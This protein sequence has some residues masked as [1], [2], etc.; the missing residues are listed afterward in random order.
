MDENEDAFSNFFYLESSRNPTNF[1]IWSINHL[2]CLAWRV[3]RD[4]IIDNHHLINE[5]IEIQRGQLVT[6]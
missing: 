1:G 2:K 6:S 5:E 4:K 3:L